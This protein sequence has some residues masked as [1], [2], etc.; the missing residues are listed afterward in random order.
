M[1]P[2]KLAAFDADDLAVVSAHL[3]DAVV[4]VSD[5]TYLPEEEATAEKNHAIYCM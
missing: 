5:I 4:R 2:L 3:Q 1:E